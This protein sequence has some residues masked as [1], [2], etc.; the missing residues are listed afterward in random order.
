MCMSICS[1]INHYIFRNSWETRTWWTGS[2][3]LSLYS[4]DSDFSSSCIGNPKNNYKNLNMKSSWLTLN[5]YTTKTYLAIILTNDAIKYMCI[6]PLALCNK[7]K[8]Y[9]SS[10][11]LQEFLTISFTSQREREAMKN[12]RTLH[13][14]MD[15]C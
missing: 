1:S 9:N 7:Y 4:L 2:S 3:E 10:T 11:P 12:E 15:K 14:A 13:G 5:R 6:W 8:L